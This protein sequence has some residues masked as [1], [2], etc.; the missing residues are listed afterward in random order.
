[1][2]RAPQV[3][4]SMGTSTFMYT[5]AHMHM[6][7]FTSPYIQR[8]QH[9]VDIRKSS[10]YTFLCVSSLSYINTGPGLHPFLLLDQIS[11]F[12][13]VSQKMGDPSF[14]LILCETLEK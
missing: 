11:P 7:T 10:A 9:K 12:F 13:N 6:L 8:K 14:P 5:C 2:S 4:D 3:N 1:M